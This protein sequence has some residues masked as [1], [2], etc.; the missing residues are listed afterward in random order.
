MDDID[1]A[2]AMMSDIKSTVS[3]M[4]TSLMELSQML[5]ASYKDDPT[6]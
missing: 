2:V 5:K 6:F 3:G 1:D 4:E